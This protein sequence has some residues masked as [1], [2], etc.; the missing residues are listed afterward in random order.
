MSL[1]EVAKSLNIEF[2]EGIEEVDLQ[3]LIDDKKEELESDI[4]HWKKEATKWETEAKTAFK[5]RD[6]FKTDRDRLSG[7]IKELET[8]M[9]NMI[10]ST[11]KEELD[12]EL[13]KLK[14]FKSEIDKAEEE[15]ELA[16]KTEVER[17]ELQM[18]KQEKSFQEQLDTKIKDI[19]GEQ[20]VTKKELAETREEAKTL[21]FHG[22]EAE[23]IRE[24]AKLD[25]W[26]PQQ[27]FLLTRD[28]FTYDKDLG[29]F[30]FQDR[31]ER[32]KLVDEMS[33][34]E[35]LKDFLSREENENLIKS[36]V[37]TSSFKSEDDKTKH[38][39]SKGD[40]GKFNPKD[41]EIIKSAELNSMTPERYI[42]VVMIPKEKLRNKDE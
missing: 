7:K 35:Y 29:K 33:V 20:E 31:D 17:L 23:I 24:A 6:T 40:L 19:M 10:P 39:T 12:E 9:D 30:S 13:S 41:P 25:A 28:I 3:K 27:I 36:K 1:K 21:R 32:D 37:N 2:D 4:E 5:K 18:K 8:S 15:K 34:P 16:Q 11:E 38:T 26:N 42:K 22:L 14:K